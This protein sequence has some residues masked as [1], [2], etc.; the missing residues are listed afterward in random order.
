MVV[1]TIG[2]DL[3]LDRGAVSNAILAAAGQNL[4]ALVHD[5]K[6]SG[7]VGDVIVTNGCNLKSSVVFHAIAPHWDKGNAE[8]VKYL[9]YL[10]YFT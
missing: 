4:Q 6:S 9:M 5:Q 2:E 10:L 8:K 3:A 1:N 7:T